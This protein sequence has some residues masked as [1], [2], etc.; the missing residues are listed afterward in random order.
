MVVSHLIEVSQ[1]EPDMLV[2]AFVYLATGLLLRIHR[3][4]GSWWS[5]VLLGLTLG[6]AYLTKS[7]MFPGSLIFLAAAAIIAARVKGGKVRLAVALAV[8]AATCVPFISALTLQRG[9]LTFG[10]SG[11]LNYAWHVNGVRN[12]NWQGGPPEA[13][14]PVHPS[15]QILAV[16]AVYEFARPTRVT[17][18]LW[19]DPSYWY[20][21]VQI[22][23]RPL[24]QA[25][26]VAL[27]LLEVC[28]FCFGS[29]ARSLSAC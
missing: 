14:R 1:T 29:R 13:G 5:F 12:R 22:V 10:E 20:E 23:F 3:R 27:N 8:F 19:Y 24:Q 4:P 15:A 2:A 6:L 17:Y 25:R 26:A 18:A 9:R 16:P 11:R 7:F 28:S 21:G